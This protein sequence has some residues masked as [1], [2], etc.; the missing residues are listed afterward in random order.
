MFV[1]IE[2]AHALDEWPISSGRFNRGRG[3]VHVSQPKSAEERIQVA[4]TFL[5]NYD[6]GE[7]LEESSKMVVVVDDPAHNAFEKAYA[8]WPL[9]LFV[10]VNGKMEWIAQPKDCSY[11]VSLLREWLTMHCLGPRNGASIACD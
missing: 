1:Y 8:P 9:R 2:E 10:I 6:L 5:G 3:P 4:R 11:D 7:T